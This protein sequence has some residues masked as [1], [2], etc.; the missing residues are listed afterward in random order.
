MFLLA[1]EN[2]T[3]ILL[4]GKYIQKYGETMISKILMIDQSNLI[5]LEKVNEIGKTSNYKNKA[6]L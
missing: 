6:H 5:S 3:H 4:C 1:G 2:I